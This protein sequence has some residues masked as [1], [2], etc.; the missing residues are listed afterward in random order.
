MRVCVCVYTLLLQ[1]SIITLH[2]S[3]QIDFIITIFRSIPG[4]YTK[5]L[6]LIL[7]CCPMDCHLW[8]NAESDHYKKYYVYLI[9]SFPICNIWFHT[10]LQG[11]P[12]AQLDQSYHLKISCSANNKCWSV[13]CP[14]STNLILK[15]KWLKLPYYHHPTFETFLRHHLPNCEHDNTMH[16]L[17][18]SFQ[19]H[20]MTLQH[21]STCMWV[22]TTYQYMYL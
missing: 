6:C 9:N 16:M 22:M 17:Q 10:Q 11:L 8:I 21:K 15:N 12:S 2:F 4:H 1:S 19:P 3:L 7:S 5:G 13:R 18:P 14:K 20:C